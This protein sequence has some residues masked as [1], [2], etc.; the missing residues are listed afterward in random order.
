MSSAA[1]ITERWMPIF[2]ST[3]T[4]TL[5]YSTSVAL[6]AAVGAPSTW[7]FRLNDL[8]DPDATG[9]GHQPM[10]FDQLMTWYNHFVVISAR[11]K[12]TFRNNAASGVTVAIRVDGSAT[13]LTT[14]DRIIEDGGL[15]MDTLEFKG[16]SG[17]IRTLDVAANVC[18][19]QAVS[20]SAL[21]SDPNLRGDAATSPV[22]L[23]YFHLV[24]WDSTGSSTTNVVA[25]V[26]LE[27]VAQF[28]EPRDMVES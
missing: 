3:I 6:G 17:S 25:D 23:S 5:R 2:P 24:C 12:V 21:T 14:I 13:P 11:I 26:I 8:F 15:T 22:E 10:G 1:R 28:M 27:Q 20:R 4:K 19:L 16:V 7:V 9:T 18:R